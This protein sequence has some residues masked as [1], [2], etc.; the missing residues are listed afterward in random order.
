MPSDHVIT[1]TDATDS[2]VQLLEQKTG[3]V[4]GSAVNK[5]LY[6]V[7]GL[8]ILDGEQGQE[9]AFQPISS[10]IAGTK[11]LTD[12]E[13]SSYNAEVDQL[14][15]I[16]DQVTFELSFVQKP[17]TEHSKALWSN[18][19]DGLSSETLTALNKLNQK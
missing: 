15:A 12:A 3:K 5:M 4:F 14:N 1:D 18:M 10:E 2:A 19:V 16:L 9:I 17:T 8:I 6:P 13:L 11:G 7:F